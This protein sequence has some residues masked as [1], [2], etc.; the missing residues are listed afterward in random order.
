MKTTYQMLINMN[1]LKF[2]ML[3]RRLATN[4]LL[5]SIISFLIQSYIITITLRD[6]AN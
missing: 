2:N 4:N 1:I 6:L 3:T 5:L